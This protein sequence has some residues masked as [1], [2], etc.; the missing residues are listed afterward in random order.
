MTCHE[1][2]PGLAD[3]D[4][5]P[6]TPCD[7]C[8]PGH[9]S[10]RHETQ[11]FACHAG[12]TDHD[13]DPAVSWSPGQ[14]F[15]RNFVGDDADPSTPL[16]ASTGCTECDLGQY[17]AHQQMGPCKNCPP[18]YTDQDLGTQHSTPSNVCGHS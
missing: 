2:Q 11:C 8:D 14:D 9:Y 13:Y 5:D 1:C 10:G 18:G 3:L 4:S 7:P 12:K 17:M 16:S 15:V 6:A